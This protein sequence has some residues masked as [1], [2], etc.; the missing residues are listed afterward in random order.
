MTTRQPGHWTRIKISAG[1]EEQQ[2][3]R[4]LHQQYSISLEGSGRSD[5]AIIYWQ[6]DADGG[7]TYLFSP[8][9]A[10]IAGLLLEPFSPSPVSGPD[11]QELR[12]GAAV[13]NWRHS[14]VN[15]R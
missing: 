1:E 10:A 15:L 12:Q 14:Y 6:A 7:R 8:E 2:K 5:E 4:R 11:L 3:E 9:A 13:A